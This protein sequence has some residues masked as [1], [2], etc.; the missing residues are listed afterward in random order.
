METPISNMTP[1][2][3]EK[4][5]GALCR[6]YTIQ[7]FGDAYCMGLYDLVTILDTYGDIIDTWW[8]PVPEWQVNHCWLMIDDGFLNQPV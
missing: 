1:L 3:V 5:W 7:F 6:G 4:K 8:L 2:L